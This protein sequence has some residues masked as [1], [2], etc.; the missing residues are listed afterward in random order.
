M[1]K[2]TFRSSK[3]L[4]ADMEAVIEDPLILTEEVA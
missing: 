2:Y 3:I 4:Y 1:K